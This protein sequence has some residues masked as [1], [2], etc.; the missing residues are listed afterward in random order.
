MSELTEREEKR[1]VTIASPAVHTNS[2]IQLFMRM[3]KIESNM[4]LSENLL[5][6]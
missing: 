4:A 2:L 3:K 5:S 6:L 1:V